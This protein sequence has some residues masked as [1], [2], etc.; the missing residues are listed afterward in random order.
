MDHMKIATPGKKKKVRFKTEVNSKW[1]AT[2][3]T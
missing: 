3:A 2:L 1:K